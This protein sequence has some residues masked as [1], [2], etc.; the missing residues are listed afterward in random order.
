MRNNKIFILMPQLFM[1]GSEKQVRYIVEGLESAGLCVTVLVE[2]GTGREKENSDYAEAHPG[3]NFV[4]LGMNT[5]NV[6]DKTKKNKTQ[7]LKKIY[8]W[9]WKNGCGYDWAMFT[10][11]TGLTCVPIC[12]LFKI[13]VLFNE[14]NP[15]VKICD[16]SWKRLLLKRCAYLVANSKSASDYMSNVLNRKVEVIN[17]GIADKDWA[18][19]KSNESKSEIKILVPARINPVKNQLV[20]LKALNEIKQTTDVRC[21]FAGQI[22]DKVYY[23]SLM[24]YVKTNNLDGLVSFPGYI[25]NMD[26]LYV[27]SS[28]IILPSYE[29]G[30][31]NV[32]LEAFLR[33]KKC[34]A[35]D[36]VMNRDIVQE[37]KLLF[38]TDDYKGLANKIYWI[39]SLEED[40]CDRILE[41]EHRFVKENYSMDVMQGKYKKI[42]NQ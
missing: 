41:G 25:S 12:K 5:L 9:I 24:D 2:N 29:E 23:D 10:N 35:S 11:L 34:L 36:I 4:F 19:S 16:S 32:V 40:E 26:D 8:G 21:V 31:P 1:G 14:R 39:C 28:V 15:G 30:T 37:K 42:F 27:E 33:R 17:N 3:V 38:G 20:V 22:E 18:K 6:E 7:S 13:K